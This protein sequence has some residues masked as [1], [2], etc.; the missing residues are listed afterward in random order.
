MKKHSPAVLAVLYTTA[1]FLAAC[2]LEPPPAVSGATSGGKTGRVVINIAGAED[3][4]APE[5]AA[6]AARTLLPEWAGLNYKLEFTRQGE[7]E[8]AITR[9]IETVTVEQDLDPGV[10]YTLK[11]TAY[12]TDPAVP[13]AEGS[14]SGVTA[15]AGQT[16]AV[17]V[18]LALNKAAAGS[19]NYNITLPAEMTLAGGSLT[20]YPLPVETVPVDIDLNAGLSGAEEISS[21]YYRARLLVYGNTGGA[22]KFAAKTGVLHI[23][24][25]LETTASY[26][27]AAGDF[28]DTD[29]TGDKVYIAENLTQLQNALNSISGDSQTVFTILVYEDI[30]SPPV[31]L[32]NSGYD[33]KT[34]I[35]R[36]NGG[37]REIS[38]SSQGHLFTIGYS[39]VET[40]FVVRD[41]TLK[42]MTTNNKALLYLYDG[43]L[44]MESGAI[45]TGNTTSSP[46]GGVQSMYGSFYMRDNALVSGNTASSYGG[47]VYIENG[48]FTMQDN[49]SVSGN[50]S[51]SYGG[52]VYTKNGSFTMRG[53]ASVS[54]NTATKS[55]EVRGGGVYVE[56]GSFT[57]EDNASVNTNTASSSGSSASGGGV[58]IDG[59]NF[60]ITGNVS[61]NGNTASS[62][63]SSARG[64][65]ICFLG[66]SSGGTFT[67]QG[68]AS[69]SGNRLLLT[70]SSSSSKAWGGG[71][72]LYTTGTT[73]TKTG[74]VIYGSNETGTGP[75]GKDLKNTAQ[76]A[77]DAI[78]LGTSSGLTK[79]RNTTVGTGQNL[80][81][82]SDANWSD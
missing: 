28:S 13:A 74:G 5:A 9:T 75:D 22:V 63:D 53:N 57:M 33:G 45:V 31:S 76:S 35:L 27:L 32:T 29:L 70:P 1:L 71:V 36:G 48:S 51:S 23:N 12:K 72:F 16:V 80:S 17:T 6:S 19:L 37:V 50:T 8:P 55:G 59:G 30:S 25:S 81:T 26:T 56:K 66:G 61:V 68:N 52:G 34:I 78:A 60:T 47:G 67:M 65:G 11:V 21:G 7:T 46:G 41:I 58:Y 79:Y 73:F 77:A 42:G 44:I 69:V 14:V 43:E 54:G 10:V 62:H 18:P 2:T 20:L 64:G 49:A 39:N 40:V 4:P 24:D 38:L 82:G 3:A 15:Q